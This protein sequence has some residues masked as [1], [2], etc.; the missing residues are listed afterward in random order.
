M[1]AGVDA[2]LGPL[3]AAYVLLTIVIAAAVQRL[4]DRL[5]ADKVSVRKDHEGS[6]PAEPAPSAEPASAR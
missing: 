6:R 1:A 5:R 3:T 2:R 4:P